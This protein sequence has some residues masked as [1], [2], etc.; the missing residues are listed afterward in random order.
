MKLSFLFKN[1]MVKGYSPASSGRVAVSS[2]SCSCSLKTLA[3]SIGWYSNPTAS[4]SIFLAPVNQIGCGAMSLIPTVKLTFSPA[5]PTIV[6]FWSL[7]SS[8]LTGAPF[9]C[10]LFISL[11]A[12][13]L[14]LLSSEDPSLESLL[15]VII[16]FLKNFL[17]LLL[18]HGPCPWCGPKCP[19]KPCCG[20]K[21]CGAPNGPI[22]PIGP[23]NPGNPA[24]SPEEL[25]SLSLEALEEKNFLNILSLLCFPPI[26]LHPFPNLLKCC[27]ALVPSAASLITFQ[28]FI[29]PNFSSEL[30]N[31]SSFSVISENLK[32]LRS[33]NLTSLLSSRVRSSIAWSTF[34]T[35]CRICVG[36]LTSTTI[37]TFLLSSWVANSLSAFK[38]SSSLR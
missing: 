19:P 35:S 13:F 11:Q 25:C 3:S 6:S 16:H 12:L 7:N 2:T 38:S 36:F 20:P 33:S 32:S 17:A 27:S 37:L 9:F 21:W 15:K 29:C 22:G 18:C 26:P 31:S 10:C 23:P 24:S 1:P 34:S 5:F 14:S 8:F 4:P 30:N 28:I